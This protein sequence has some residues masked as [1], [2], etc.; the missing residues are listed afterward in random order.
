MKYIKT[1]EN[2][3]FDTDYVIVNPIGIRSEPT[4]P[5]IKEAFHEFINN[6]VGSVLS[7][8]DKIYSVY[9]ENIPKKLIPFFLYNFGIKKYYISIKEEKILQK[10]KN[11]EDLE[12]YIQAKKYN[13]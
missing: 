1:F 9:Y 11:K 6:N 2:N 13:L 3:R 5:K 4:V 7:K 8:I 12:A 10:S